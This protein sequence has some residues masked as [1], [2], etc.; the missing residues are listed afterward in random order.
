VKF[1]FFSSRAWFPL[2]MGAA[3][4]LA[5]APRIAGAHVGQQHDTAPAAVAPVTI[6][7]AADQAVASVSSPHAA[8][9]NTCPGGP[10]N[11]CCCGMRPA[12]TGSG[13]TPVVSSGGWNILVALPTERVKP[14]PVGMAPLSRI[15]VSASPRA[16]P[17]FS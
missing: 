16:P 17:S 12:S 11:T 14:L 1:K 2:L 9:S 10:G 5:A 15:P 8:L 3:L 6:P 7:A 13:K 4:L